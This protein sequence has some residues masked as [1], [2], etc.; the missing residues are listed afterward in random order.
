MEKLV[1]SFLVFT[2][3]CCKNNTVNHLDHKHQSRKGEEVVSNRKENLSPSKYAMTMID[4]AHIH[5]DY[6]SP[7]VRGRIIYGG[8]L[9][10][11][12]IWQSGAHNATWISTNKDLLINDNLLKAGKYGFFTIPNKE[13]WTIIFNKNWKQHGKD[14]YN[15]AD[16]VFRFDVKPKISE[17]VKENLTYRV[18]KIGN[19]QGAISLSWEKITISFPFFVL[20]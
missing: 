20:N 13:F 8:L 3:V 11:G 4:G 16:D 6:S 19:Q 15:Q 9:A 2:H 5:I 18:E 17:Q 14:E 12:D 1:L 7:S 10:Y